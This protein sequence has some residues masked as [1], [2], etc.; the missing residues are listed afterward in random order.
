MKTNQ[1][2][3]FYFDKYS[4]IKEN[5]DIDTL[6][7]K[8]IKGKCGE[9]ERYIQSKQFITY[10][11]HIRRID[12]VGLMRGQELIDMKIEDYLPLIN[13]KLLY[14]VILCGKINYNYYNLYTN[15]YESYGYYT[16]NPLDLDNIRV[17]FKIKQLVII[18]FEQEKEAI[19]NFNYNKE[20]FELYKHEIS[21]QL[22]DKL[23]HGPENNLIQ[24]N[25]VR[26][27]ILLLNEKSLKKC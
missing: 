24:D 22:L 14:K 16:H 27:E 8:K 12:S 26:K 2:D 19:E 18:P 10:T 5:I 1:S 21:P 15:D 7:G 6:F 17:V 4:E 13:Q 9:W 3:S 20:L 23:I 25:N 11:N